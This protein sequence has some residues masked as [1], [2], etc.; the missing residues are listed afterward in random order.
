MLISI[1]PT[2]WRC[3]R[4]HRNPDTS[5]FLFSIE[6]STVLGPTQPSMK[7]VRTG[8]TGFKAALLWN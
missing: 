7:R 6:F 2:A 8:L 3:N 4:K 5:T 1:H